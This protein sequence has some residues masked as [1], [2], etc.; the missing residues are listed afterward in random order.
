MK[1]VGHAAFVKARLKCLV[2]LTWQGRQTVSKV[3]ERHIAP[4]CFFI[5]CF[6]VEELHSFTLL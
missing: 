2:C 6:R 4:D 3:N 1:L 5:S